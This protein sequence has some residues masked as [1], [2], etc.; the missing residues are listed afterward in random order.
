VSS[1]RNR[2]RAGWVTSACAKRHQGAIQL[3]VVDPSGAVINGADLELV[4]Y[5]TN[6]TRKA[7]T[8][9]KGTYS[10]VN[11]PIGTYRL[12]C[13]KSGFAPKIYES[14]EVQAAVVN[15]LNVTL[16][17]GAVADAVRV[18]ATEIP[19]LV[20]SSNA[21]GTIVDMKQIEELPLQGRDITSLSRLVP[22]W[23]GTFN[24]A[25]CI[26]VIVLEI[27]FFKPLYEAI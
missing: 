12:T 27:V 16:T 8:D 18:T 22:G 10:F 26:I 21:V 3:T 5:D 9:S 14:V 15:G 24:L 4:N 2:L 19:V 1:V 20:T 23:T 25:Q 7:E 13:T 17:V 11:L 6:D